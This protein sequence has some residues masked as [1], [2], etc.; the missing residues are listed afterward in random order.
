MSKTIVFL[1]EEDNDSRLLLRKS[2]KDAGY[3]ISLA[4]DEEDALERVGGGCVKADLIL[5]NLLGK[6]PDE[7]LKIGRNIRR[8]GNI[9]A[10]LIVIAQKYGEDLEGTNARFG[11]NEYITYL[12][13]G[14]QLFDLIDRLTA[15]S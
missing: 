5:I 8:T 15:R 14:D 1:I 10:P 13:D 9:N 4:I 11:E 2:L 7:V 6:S 3:R 12:E